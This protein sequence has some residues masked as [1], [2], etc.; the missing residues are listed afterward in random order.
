MK[1][2]SLRDLKR[3]IY[4]INKQV[5]NENTFMKDINL[6][7]IEFIEFYLLLQKDFPFITDEQINSIKITQNTTLKD[8]YHALF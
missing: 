2:L 7:S 5:V 1:E 8:F 4:T 6:D 3:Y